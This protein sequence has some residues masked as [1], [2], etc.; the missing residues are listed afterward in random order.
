MVIDTRRIGI[1]SHSARF[2]VI[3]AG[4]RWGKTTLALI[5][6]LSGKILPEELRW[7]VAPTYRQGKLVAWRAL[8][9]MLRQWSG[10]YEIN[11]SDL[12]VMLPNNSIVSIKGA[13]NEDS[14]RGVGLAR[15]V[16]DE[17]AYMKATAWTEVLRPMLADTQGGAMFIGTPDGYN[18][19]YDLYL[20]GLDSPNYKSW[21]FKSSDG[22]FIP[23][24]ELEQARKDMDART[25]RQEFEASFETIAS[26]VYYTFDRAKH[27]ALKPDYCPA[28]PLI[29]TFDFNV[30][31]MHAAIIQESHDVSYQ[32]D[33]IVIPTS[34]TSE[35]CQEFLRRY[36]QHR[37]PVIVC[38]DASGRARTTKSHQTDYEI[39]RMILEP[40]FPL[41]KIEVPMA[42]PAVR[43]R[44][45]A[46]NSRLLS[47]TGAI[48]Y[49]VHPKCK[50]TINSFE[51]V[52]YKEGTG[53]IDKQPS[54]EHITDAIGYYINQRFPI[55]KTIAGSISR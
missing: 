38:G 24:E 9:Q 44:V 18:H 42:N 7:Y 52:Q 30:N 17:Y 29:V 22:G 27:T 36:G 47:G 3:A 49:Y 37:T 1:L 39:I 33:E 23:A 53:E 31:P 54:I 26:R 8:K 12:S 46:V 10:R 16:L 45:N 14:L 50:V 25:Y 55:I 40:K 48:R 34:N 19:F 32:L 4:R 20:R 15:A 51:R 43:D 41:V 35:V 13:D 2:K 21:Q 11:E 28:L 6:L 5:Y